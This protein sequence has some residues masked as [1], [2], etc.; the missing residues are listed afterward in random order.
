M[1]EKDRK[2]LKKNI[3]LIIISILLLFLAPLIILKGWNGHLIHLVKGLPVLSYWNVFWILW[4][5][6]LLFAV[7]KRRKG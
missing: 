5:F 4:G 3:E 1:T 2:K 6:R 7:G